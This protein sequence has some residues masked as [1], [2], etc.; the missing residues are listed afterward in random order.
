MVF[1]RARLIR[2]VS[3]T[4]IRRASTQQGNVLMSKNSAVVHRDPKI[5][6]GTPVFVG[7]RVPLESLYD[8]LE[9][10]APWMNV[11]TTFPP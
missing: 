6:S 8:Y 5:L 2:N 9:G 11:W 1:C 4:E 7:T 3:H 10:G